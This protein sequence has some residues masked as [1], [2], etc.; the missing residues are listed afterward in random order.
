MFSEEG[1]WYS[2]GTY[3]TL[4]SRKNTVKTGGSYAVPEEPSCLRFMSRKM[5][6]I[7]YFCSSLLHRHWR[8]E[9]D[10]SDR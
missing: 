6:P 5:T 8:V 10:L 1:A 7:V 9:S 3:F 4:L 2:K